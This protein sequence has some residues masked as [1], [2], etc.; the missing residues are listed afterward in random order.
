M[1]PRNCWL[2]VTAAL[3]WGPRA[4]N[5]LVLPCPAISPAHKL[6]AGSAVWLVVPHPPALCSQIMCL[7]V[8]FANLASPGLSD[9]VTTF[10]PSTGVCISPSFLLPKFLLRLAPISSRGKNSGYR[11]FALY[12]KIASRICFY[13]PK[14][15]SGIETLELRQRDEAGAGLSRVWGPD[16]CT[17]LKPQNLLS[18]YPCL[19][20]SPSSSLPTLSEWKSSLWKGREKTSYF[21]F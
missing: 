14:S 19:V 2:S 20:L 7:P 13:F 6:P 21:L 11:G 9:S 4:G 8:S 3:S 1:T 5:L 18:E 17:S 10:I 15:V 12:I 16:P